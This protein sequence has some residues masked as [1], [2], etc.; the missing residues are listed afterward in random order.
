ML[1]TS[2]SEGRKV[3]KYGV[4]N[5]TTSLSFQFQVYSINN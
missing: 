1:E 2:Y 3:K 5:F 4:V